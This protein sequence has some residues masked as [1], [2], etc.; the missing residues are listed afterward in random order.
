METESRGSLVGPLGFGWTTCSV[1]GLDQKSGC[2]DEKLRPP[3]CGWEWQ[4]QAPLQSWGPPGQDMQAAQPGGPGYRRIR[5]RLWKCR[6]TSWTCLMR[7]TRTGFQFLG[8]TECGKAIWVRSGGTHGIQ[9]RE[10]RKWN[11]PAT[12]PSI[13]ARQGVPLEQEGL[14]ARRV[15][16]YRPMHAFS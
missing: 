1:A 10:K 7:K 13:R 8:G 6:A 12:A 3:R 16:V 2:W 14:C 5:V 4:A 15:C 11:P 9:P